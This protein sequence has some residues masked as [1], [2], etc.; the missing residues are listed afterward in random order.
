MLSSQTRQGRGARVVLEEIAPDSHRSGRL[1]R[2]K[3]VP[4][5]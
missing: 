5:G 3:Q 2:E 4:E 1:L